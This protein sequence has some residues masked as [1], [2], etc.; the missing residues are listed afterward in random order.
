MS[1]VSSGRLA[2][3]TPRVAKVQSACDIVDVSADAKPRWVAVVGSSVCQSV[4]EVGQQCVIA[5]DG[6]DDLAP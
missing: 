6:Q 4:G 2:G 5:P 1:S 3:R